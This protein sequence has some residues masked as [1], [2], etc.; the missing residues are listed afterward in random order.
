MS[1]I[2]PL[3]INDKPFIQAPTVLVIE[4]HESQ[5]KYIQLLLKKLKMNV[6]ATAK[7]DKAFNL[8]SIYKIDCVLLDINLGK[9][10]SGLEI[11]SKL[12]NSNKYLD[13]PIIAVTS[14]YGYEHKK[15]FIEAG[16]DDYIAKPFSLDHLQEVLDNN[17]FSK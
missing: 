10:I 9:G 17:L 16:F 15:D 7:Q 5:L 6:I 13:I 3:F 2:D 12:R 8:A 1:G 11:M 14:Y 4:D